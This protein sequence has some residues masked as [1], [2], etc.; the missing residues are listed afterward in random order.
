MQSFIKYNLIINS[1]RLINLF[2][3]LIAP[4]YLQIDHLVKALEPIGR[5]SQV[6]PIHFFHSI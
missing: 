3:Q 5:L 1:M 4:S 2:M 6:T